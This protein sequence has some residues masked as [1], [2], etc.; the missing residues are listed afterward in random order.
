MVKSILRVLFD[1][2]NFLLDIAIS[3]DIEKT[4]NKQQKTNMLIINTTTKKVA[5]KNV[6]Y[7]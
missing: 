6:A 1:K 2:N 5:L 7:L 4:K 3:H